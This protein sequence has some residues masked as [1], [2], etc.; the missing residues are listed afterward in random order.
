MS[1][2][3]NSGTTLIGAEELS[4]EEMKQAIERMIDLFKDRKERAKEAAVSS[5][6]S[7]KKAER[8]RE[9]AQDELAFH[10]LIEFAGVLAVQAGRLNEA[11]HEFVEEISDDDIEL[12]ESLAEDKPN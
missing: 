1:Q 8:F 6:S 4:P 12:D 2:T 7:I 9:T 11:V 10:R 5:P 3:K